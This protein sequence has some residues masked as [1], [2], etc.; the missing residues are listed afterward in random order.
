MNEFLTLFTRAAKLM[1]AAADESMSQ[2]GVRVGQ[3]LVLE[4]LWATD[5]LTPGEIAE[6]VHLS[7]PTVVNTANRMVT[8]GLVTKKRDRTDGRL[9]RLYLTD[10]ARSV[11]GDIEAGRDELERRAT[12]GLTDAERKAM[13]VAFRKMIATLEKD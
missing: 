12:S 10:R 5:G 6:R 1:R 4:A 11:R 7:T 2:H 9:V 13:L 3:N 8:G